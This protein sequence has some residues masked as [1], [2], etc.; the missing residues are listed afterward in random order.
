MD[1]WMDRR[2]DGETE[3]MD[4]GWMGRWVDGQISLYSNRYFPLL[5]HDQFLSAQ[6][7]GELRGKCQLYA[8]TSM[9]SDMPAG[10]GEAISHY[11]VSDTRCSMCKS[12]EDFFW[13]V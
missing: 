3:W 4:N 11:L 12:Q 7:P 9:L 13:A 8:M 6:P 2:V 10:T 1:G 5:W